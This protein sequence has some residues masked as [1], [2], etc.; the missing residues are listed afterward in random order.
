MIKVS[1]WLKKLGADQGIL[2]YITIDDPKIDKTV[3]FDWGNRYVCEIYLSV[4]EKKDHL[5]YGVNPVDAL[6]L[7]SEFARTYLQGL[8]KCGYTI[9]EVENRK[10]WKLEKLSDNYLQEKIDEIKSNKDISP[11]DKQKILGILRESFSK[12]TI[13]EQLDKLI[14]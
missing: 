10:S 12:T 2:E 5:V 13:K 4:S 6:C 7:A 1:F 11:E 9:S 14:W 3:K 8:I